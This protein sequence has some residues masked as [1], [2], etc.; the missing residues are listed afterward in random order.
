MPILLVALSSTRSRSLTFPY[1][2]PPYIASP[3]LNQLAHQLLSP[4]SASSSLLLTLCPDPEPP[5]ARRLRLRSE[6]SLRF[7]LT[8]PASPSALVLEYDSGRAAKDMRL[9]VEVPELGG[10]CRRE[11]GVERERRARETRVPMLPSPPSGVRALGS[12]I[13]RSLPLTLPFPRGSPLPLDS[14]EGRNCS[15]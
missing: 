5:L 7:R 15:V 14:D 10:V 12:V 3:P 9:G 13:S 4:L 6:A 11:A 2:C 8:E 1:P